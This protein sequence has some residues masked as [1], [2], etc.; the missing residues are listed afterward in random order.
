L[1]RHITSKFIDNISL[2]TKY[3]YTTKTYQLIKIC[4]NSSSFPLPPPSFKRFNMT[5]EPEK[6]I[7]QRNELQSSASIK[8]IKGV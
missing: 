5:S 6:F 4:P 2:D 7:Y 8:Q 3:T 1:Y